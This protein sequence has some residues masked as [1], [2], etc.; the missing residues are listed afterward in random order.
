MTHTL[1]DGRVRKTRGSDGPFAD[2]Y[3]YDFGRCSY[4]NGWAQIDTRQDAPYYGTW[5]NPTTRQ[6]FNYCEGDVYLTECADDEAFAAMVR[7]T[8]DWNKERGYWLGIDPG[9]DG[10]GRPGDGMRERFIALGLA[11]LLH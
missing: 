5:C 2:R 7:E 8:A 10:P 3:K 6:I 1:M 11:D 4:A 9:F